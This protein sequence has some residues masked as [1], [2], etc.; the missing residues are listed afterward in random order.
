MKG[1]TNPKSLTEQIV[2]LNLP[3]HFRIPLWNIKVFFLPDFLLP[4]YWVYV[5]FRSFPFNEIWKRETWE[6]LQD[7]PIERVELTGFATFS[8]PCVSPLVKMWLKAP[9]KNGTVG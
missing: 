9:S 2:A 6:T 8:L 7:W 4:V 3:L 5:F 1:M